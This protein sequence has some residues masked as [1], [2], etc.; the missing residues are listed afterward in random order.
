MAY[1]LTYKWTYNWA[2]A[3]IT[4]YIEEETLAHLRSAAK[5]SGQSQSQWIAEAVR[6][7]MKREWPAAVSA[8]AGAWAYFPSAEEIRDR[9]ASDTPREPM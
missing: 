9:Q 4:I 7:R 1:H 6:L 2:M 3:Q 8:L 5:A